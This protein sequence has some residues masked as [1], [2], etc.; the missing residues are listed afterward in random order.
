MEDRLWKGGAWAPHLGKEVESAIANRAWHR[1]TVRHFSSTRPSRLF[2]TKS[3]KSINQSNRQT[4]GPGIAP[5]S[6]TSPAP[7]SVVFSLQ[8]HENPSINQTVKQQ[9]LAQDHCQTLLQHQAQSSFLYKHHKQYI[10]QSSFCIQT[11]WYYQDLNC[12]HI[13]KFMYCFLTYNLKQIFCL[14]YWSDP[15]PRY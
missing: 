6:D 4:A 10:N 1:T 14:N 8:N 9:G 15:D 11:Y 5:P 13:G 3:C 2:S 12:K 7:G